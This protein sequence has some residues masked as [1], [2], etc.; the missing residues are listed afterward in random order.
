MG[1]KE[2]GKKEVRRREKKK[3]TGRKHETPEHFKFYKAGATLER[4]KPNC[5]R[6]GPGTWL[7]THE[8]RSACGRCGY[9]VIGKK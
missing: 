8:N 6:C 1:C 9:A 7:A 2:G 5:P 3:R 4:L